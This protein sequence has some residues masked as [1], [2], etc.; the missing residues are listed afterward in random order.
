[1]AYNFLCPKPSRMKGFSLLLLALSLFV[2]GVCQVEAEDYYFN[3]EFE[4]NYAGMHWTWKLDIPKDLYEDYKSVSVSRR[5]SSQSEG[6]GFLTTTND[7]YL[8]MVAEELEEAASEQ[9]YEDYDKV[10]FV[11]AFVQSLPY[12]SDSITSGYDEYPRFPLETLVDDGGDCEDTSILF[13][14]IIL[15]MDYGTIYIAPPDHCAVGVLGDDL[16]GYYW[17]FNDKTYYYC[18]TTGD[19]WRIGDLP[20]EYL[21]EEAFMYEIKVANQY[22]PGSNNVDFSSNPLDMTLFFVAGLVIFLLIAGLAIAKNKKNAAKDSPKPTTQ[23]L[24]SPNKDLE[25]SSQN[26]KFCRYCGS[27]NPPDTIFCEKCGKQIT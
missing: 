23:D 14:T 6:Y 5:V 15:I 4:W 27:N 25:A 9:G 17:T 12:T 8:R 13:A 19:N 2:L 11:L 3:K 7:P 1:M 18:E 21:N 10:S 22:L 16:P 20:E 26:G 24:N